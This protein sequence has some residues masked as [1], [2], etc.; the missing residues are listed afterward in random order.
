MKDQLRKFI[1]IL[2][3]MGLV[4]TLG[5]TFDVLTVPSGDA[6]NTAAS[7]TPIWADSTGKELG[8]LAF[9][10]SIPQGV[11]P[12]LNGGY[13]S[14]WVLVPFGVNGVGY[15]TYVSPT[16]GPSMSG[17]QQFF[18]ATNCQG[19]AYALA[20]N[21]I[22]LQLNSKLL[23]YSATMGVG[24]VVYFPIGT[25]QLGTKLVIE[26]TVT[27]VG[28]SGLGDGLPGPC[29]PTAAAPGEYFAPIQ[30]VNLDNGDYFQPKGFTPP[31]SL[32]VP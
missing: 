10:D 32:V 21:P 22:I 23:P 4:P 27:Y 26:T 11:V 12:S 16:Y 7:T 29:L 20:P 9:S 17:D 14:L 3:A 5:H 8:P 30:Q 13:R 1:P 25:P 24:Q 6:Q 15:D 2:V 19:T 28:I 18:T 31:W